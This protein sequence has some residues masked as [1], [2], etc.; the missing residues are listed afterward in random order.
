MSGAR[1][2][3]AEHLGNRDHRHALDRMPE[4]FQ[5]S[6]LGESALRPEIGNAHGLFQRQTSRHDFPKQTGH[7]FV[8][9]RTLAALHT[10]PQHLGLPLWTVKYR[11]FF[12]LGALLFLT[13]LLGTPRPLA[14][15]LLD[16]SIDL[17]NSLA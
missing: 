12:A 4:V 10:R 17:I 5:R 14:D 2:H 16:F 11:L 3:L 15:Q 8:T 13:N 7:L 9:K 1:F 6:R